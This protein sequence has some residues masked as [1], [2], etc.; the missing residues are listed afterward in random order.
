MKFLSVGPE[1]FHVDGQTDKQDEAPNSL[2]VIL[3]TGLKTQ[4]T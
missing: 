4:N 2:F 1:L 3:R